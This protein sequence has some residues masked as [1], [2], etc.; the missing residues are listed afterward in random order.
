MKSQAARF[1]FVW[2][3]SENLDGTDLDLTKPVIRYIKKFLTSILTTQLHFR[4]C[5]DCTICISK[6]NFK[7]TNIEF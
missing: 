5:R 3:P 2:M 7:K 6:I 1:C 4:N